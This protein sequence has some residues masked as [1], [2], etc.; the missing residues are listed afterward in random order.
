MPTRQALVLSSK[1]LGSAQLV[2]GD[3]EEVL[4]KARRGD[5]VYMDPPYS[6]KAQRV[7]KE[8]SS[9]DFG[10]DAV[11]RL[12]NGMKQL[13]RNGITF[14]VSYAKSSEALVLRK[15]FY[16]RAVTVRRNIAGFTDR[17]KRTP[18]ILISNVR[19]PSC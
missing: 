3:F 7:F 2:A 12:R 10:A 1:L 11:V 19:I 16:W 9:I 6:V 17:R 18:E 15:G 8:Y 4:S 5:F 13:D 14:L